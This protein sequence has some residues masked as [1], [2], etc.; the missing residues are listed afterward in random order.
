MPLEYDGRRVD[1]PEGR[2]DHNAEVL[3]SIDRTV[4]RGVLDD[5]INHAALPARVDGAVQPWVPLGPRNVG[6]RIRVLAQDPENANTLYAGSAFGGLWRTD[7]S[8]DTWHPLDD[9]RPPNPPNAVRQAPPIGAVAIAPGNRRILYVGTGEPPLR[10]DGTEY[11]FPGLGLYRSTDGGATFQQID[12]PDAPAGPPPLNP[13]INARRYERIVVDPV[14]PERCW[15]ACHRGLW[16]REAGAVEFRQDVIDAATAPAAAAQNA[17]DIAVDF[18]SD[19]AS[20]ATYTVYVA[21]HSVGIFRATFNRATADYAVPAGGQAWTHLSDGIDVATFNRIKIAVCRSQ[22]SRLYAVFGLPDRSAS[23]VFRSVDKGDH[24]VKTSTRTDD[25]G[26]Q[27]NYDLVLEVHPERPEIVFTGSVELFRST[28]SGGSWT[29]VIEWTQYDLGDRAQHADQHAF[30]FDGLNPR[31]IWVGNDGGI[32]MSPDLGATWRKRS[33]GILAGQFYDVTVNPGLAF[34]TG[35]GLQDNGS[36]VGLGGPTWFHLYGGDGGAMAFESGNPQRIYATV[37]GSSSDQ[38]GVNRCDL[39]LQA[40]AAPL[41]ANPRYMNRLPDLAAG[42]GSIPKLWSNPQRLMANF[43]HQGPFVGIIEHHPTV[44]NHLLVGRIGDAYVSTDGTTFNAA[45]LAGLA[46]NEEVSALAYSPSD[47]TNQIWWA[48]TS[49]GQLFRTGDGGASWN[50]I[51]LP[52]IGNRWIS[53]V[54][55][56]PADARIVAVAVARSPGRVYLTGDNGLT[57]E[58]ISG[59]SAPAGVPPG[60]TSAGPN[61]DLNPS[62]ITSLVFDPRS[63]APA[64]GAPVTLYVG[65]LAGVY[66]IRNAVP[67]PMPAPPPPPPPAPPPPPPASPAPVWRTFNLGLPLTLIYDLDTVTEMLGTAPAITQRAAIRCGTHGRGVWECDLDGLPDVRLL[68]RDT[69][70]DDGRIRP[71][72]FTRDPRQ[73]PMPPLRFD[74]AFDIRVD[75]P[76][77]SFFEETM[78]GVE[79]DEDLIND[80]AVAGERNLVYVQIHQTGSRPVVNDAKVNLY[81]AFSPGVSPPLQANFWDTFPDGDPPAA[82]PWHRAAP[83]RTTRRLAPGQPEVLRFE[84]TPPADAPAQVALLALCTQAADDLKNPV[85]TLTVDPAAAPSLVADRRAALRLV[86]VQ[87]FSPQVFV[88]DGADDSGDPGATAWG[89]RSP[90]IIPSEDEVVNPDEELKDLAD[91]R[92]EDTLVGGK[93]NF[94]YVRVHNR[95]NVKLTAEV[96]LYRVPYDTLH[97]PLTWQQVGAKVTVTDVPEKGWKFAPK[98]E[99]DGPPPED[100]GPSKVHLVVALISRAGDPKPDTASI[101]DLDT[102]WQFFLQGGRANNAAL[103]AL[104]WRP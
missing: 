91:L 93:K 90:D 37:Q 17:T 72:P 97:Q 58:E 89:G 83:Q 104:R 31:K 80:A 85:P 39:Q 16:R 88:R 59:R 36:W 94:M 28:D 7:D 102:F 5:A 3:G 69:P 46:A 96:E 61:D 56:H 38:R 95:K 10:V 79:F 70:I 14:D 6:G 12:P 29:K 84:W 34:I 55:V 52:G 66:V 53:R 71:A 25:D 103:R 73:T 81:Y 27:A 18:G 99:W 20:A 82:G 2:E 77:F 86:S 8:G 63:A 15:I 76:P 9:F 35:G 45:G 47:A 57:W 101:T 68:I 74:Q 62:P 33:H 92:V 100:P 43:A 19:P 48:G 21:L 4:F 75:A 24:W 32:S 11:H 40:P 49:R 67:P 13:Q 98:I 44:A 78:D 1:N 30:L 65:T 26:K 50:P 60:P 54:A 22:P 42:P 51:A 87:P 64:P 41:P 23:D